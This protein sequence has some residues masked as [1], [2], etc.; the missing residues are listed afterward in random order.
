[1]RERERERERGGWE[2]KMAR[3]RDRLRERRKTEK[4]ELR[5]NQ[6]FGIKKKLLKVKK[7]YFNDIG[8]IKKIYCGVYLDREPKSSFVP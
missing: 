6:F 4:I 7:Y 2:V 8:K 1:M 5:D 3:R